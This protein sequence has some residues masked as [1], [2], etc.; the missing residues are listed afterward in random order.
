M[1]IV[2]T[3]AAILGILS[4]AVI[5]GTDVLAAAVLRSAY[6]DVDDRTLVQSAGRGHYY[7]D[8]RLPAAGITGVVMSVAACVL[9]FA[10]GS[11]TAGVLAA[12]AVALLLV[13]LVLFARIAK[14]INKTLTDAALADVVP[15]NAR[16]LQRR[17][18]SIIDVRA[19]LQ[20]LALLAMCVSLVV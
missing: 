6:A 9:A 14:P 4:V 16:A 15:A 10:G 20:G 19:V 7:G 3:F 18:E 5:F 8:R 1:D 13:W 2:F 12:L 17:W 11:P